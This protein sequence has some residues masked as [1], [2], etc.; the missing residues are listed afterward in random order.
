MVGIEKIFTRTK[1]QFVAY[2]TSIV[3]F[4]TG[5]GIAL[6]GSQDGFDSNFF[7]ESSFSEDFDPRFSKLVAVLNVDE[8]DLV[9]RDSGEELIRGDFD[10]FTRKP[11]IVREYINDVAKVT[12]TRKEN[13][14][15]GGAVQIHTDEPQ[16][17]RLRFSDKVPLDLTCNGE[18]SDLHLNL[19]TTPVEKLSLNAD[20]ASI[21]IKLGDLLPNITVDIKG[22]NSSLKLRLPSQIAI[23]V[24]DN[25]YR[26][27]FETIGLI[28]KDSNLYV[29]DTLVPINSNV[30]LDMDSRLSSF[31]LDYF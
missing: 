18:R 20:D 8:T 31:S 9:I 4:A 3:L 23:K 2:G 15:L 25:F 26:S 14:F 5:I 27:Y 13:S 28:E 19:S 1:L 21:Y 7:T 12:L 11:L 30:T 16:D 24:P 6:Y 10:Q 17:W 22:D 29:K